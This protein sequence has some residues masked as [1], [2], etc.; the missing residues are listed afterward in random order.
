LKT[1]IITITLLVLF[2]A[3][4]LAALNLTAVK[5]LNKKDSNIDGVKWTW[6]KSKKTPK[7][8]FRKGS[9]KFDYDNSLF[10]IYIVLKGEKQAFLRMYAQVEPS[11]EW[12]KFN[13]IIVTADGYTFE[14]EFIPAKLKASIGERKQLIEI[15][16]TDVMEPDFKML[17]AMA[18]AIKVTIKFIGPK[19]DKDISL[20]KKDKK[21][22][23]DILDAWKKLNS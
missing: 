14:R 10:Y 13:K 19:S 4:N 16:D 2:A 22:I 5:N 15:H 1:K 3:V 9:R 18:S 11:F 6:L 21:A 8:D 12:I 7:K 23:Q 17:E 20:S